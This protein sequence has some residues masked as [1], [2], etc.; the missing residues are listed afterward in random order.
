MR[1]TINVEAPSPQ[2]GLAF[3]WEDGYD[4]SVS[5][6]AGEVVVAANR[7]GLISLARHL[8][9]LAQDGVTPGSHLHLTAGQELESTCDLVLER[10]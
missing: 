2:R 1:W 4:I 8:L 6:E 7:E 3:G 5:A 9:T 10:R